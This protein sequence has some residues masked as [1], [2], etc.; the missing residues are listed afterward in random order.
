MLSICRLLTL[1]IV[2][3]GACTL[4]FAV[5]ANSFTP[6]PYRNAPV[7]QQMDGGFWRTDGTFRPILHITNYLVDQTLVV[8]PVL[9]MADGT[10]YDLTPVTLPAAETTGVDIVEALD[11]LPGSQ[12]SHLSEY[13]S[14][15]VKY[16]WHWSNAVKAMVQNLDIP[17]SLNYNFLLRTPMKMNGMSM[18]AQLVTKEGMWWKEDDGISGF[19]GISNTSEHS[20]SIKVQVFGTGVAAPLSVQDVA[21][22]AHNTSSLQLDLS[23]AEMGG[24]RVTYNGDPHDVVLSGGLENDSEGYSAQIPFNLLDQ[25]EK[26]T[27]IGVGS[28]GLMQGTPDAMMMFP[29]NTRFHMYIAMRNVSAQKISVVPTLYYMYG[30]VVKSVTLP[31][32]LLRPGYTSFQNADDLL[33]KVHLEGINGSMNLVFVYH[34][35][36]SDVVM[37][38]GSVDQTKNYVFEVEP[39]TLGAAKSRLLGGWNLAAGNDTMISLLNPADRAQKIN[40]TFY[41]AGGKFSVPVLLRPGESK[42]FTV[43]ELILNQPPFAQKA[44]IPIDHGSATMFGDN[45][46]SAYFGVVVSIAVF[47]VRSATCGTTCPTCLAYTGDYNVVATNGQVDVGQNATFQAW[48]LLVNGGWHEVTARSDEGVTTW[49][50]LSGSVTKNGQGSFHADAVGNF[51]V[52]AATP[53]IDGNDCPEGSHSPCP[54]SVYSGGNGGTVYGLGSFAISVTSIPIAGE[55]NSVVSAQSAQVKVTAQDTRGYVMLSYSGTVH[56]SSTDGLAQLPS[57]YT[58]TSTD[59]GVHT[60]AATILTVAGTSPTRDLTVRDTVLSVVSTQNIYVWWYVFMDTEFWKNCGFVSCPSP[61]S[62]FCKTAYLSNG[63]SNPTAFLALPASGYY[64]QN[65]TIRTSSSRQSSFVGDYGPVFN[66]PYWNSGQTPPSHAGCLSDVLATNL[67]VANGCNGNQA[68]GSSWVYWRFG[69]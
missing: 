63:Y 38:T 30:N 68:Y 61:G 22:P 54:W 47:N 13:G 3:T 36:P 55:T 29:L 31:N 17:R 1:S 67:G 64:Q 46:S 9:Y 66:T 12:R 41:Y 59:N 7:L 52:S 28:A 35:R 56:F 60:F 37:A 5:D 40:I 69:L 32:L 27:N 10:E 34:A 2:L 57:N 45:Q 18:P 48:A 43:S 21:L 50:V 51:L 23:G 58:F 15:G 25:S 42:M 62:Y 39:Q 16:I 4:L 11:N 20:L 65:V 8:T 44:G 53:L 49:T 6:P 26:A 33:R 19:L 14:A 24:V